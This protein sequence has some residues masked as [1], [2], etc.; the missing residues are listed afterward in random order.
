MAAGKETG[1]IEF[2]ARVMISL[3]SVQGEPDGIEM[4]IIKNK[5]GP[6]WPS[7]TPIY[8]RIDRPRMRIEE[9]EA[10]ERPAPEVMAVD[11]VVNDA[12]LVV[13]IMVDRPGIVISKLYPAMRSKHGKFSEDRVDTALDRLGGAIEERPGAKRAVHLYVRGERVPNEV[14]AKLPPERVPAVLM[15]RPPPIAD[16]LSKADEAGDE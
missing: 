14:L 13:D 11:K 12:A 8:R 9:A 3:R 7:V 5:H 10:P 16:E 6:S 4:R 1:A 15:S 2:S